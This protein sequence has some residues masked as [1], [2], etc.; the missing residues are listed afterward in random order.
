MDHSCVHGL[1]NRKYKSFESADKVL[2]AS[3]R[4]LAGREQK[5]GERPS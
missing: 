1:M 3:P 5:T 2:D 4:L